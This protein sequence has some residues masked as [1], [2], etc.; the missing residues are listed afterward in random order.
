MMLGL[1][2]F[3]SWTAYALEQDSEWAEMPIV[4]DELRLNGVKIGIDPGH[5]AKGNSEQETI[6]PTSKETK[7]KVSSGTSGVK[8]GVAEYGVN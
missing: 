4:K 1:L 8:S 6:S 3:F 5:Q 7:A 2:V